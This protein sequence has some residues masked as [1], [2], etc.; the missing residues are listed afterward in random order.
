MSQRVN[1]NGDSL[2]NEL[3]EKV[4]KISE[5][6]LFSFAQPGKTLVGWRGIYKEEGL[7]SLARLN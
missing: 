5:L 7:L 4:I 3:G 1:K 2:S 6:K